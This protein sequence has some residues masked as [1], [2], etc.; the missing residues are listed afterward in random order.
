[1]AHLKQNS[2]SLNLSK[3]KFLLMSSSHNPIKPDKFHIS[4]RVCNI[5]RCQSIKYAG[6]QIDELLS[7]KTYIEFIK[8][9][10]SQTLA[11]LGKLTSLFKPKKAHQNLLR[12]FLSSHLIWYSWM[13]KCE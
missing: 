12:V 1:M 7:W 8:G 5:K 3:T 13:G 11:V 9:K 4:I 10:L 6:V 2:L